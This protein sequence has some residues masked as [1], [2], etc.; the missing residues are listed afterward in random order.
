MIAIGARLDCAFG[1]EC[2]T[3]HRVTSF[4]GGLGIDFFL[5][6]F[7]CA[8]SMPIGFY[9]LREKILSQ[10]LTYFFYGMLALSALI[11]FASAPFVVFYFLG[12]LKIL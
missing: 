8:I 7:T 2:N 6:P 5:S 10:N 9:L 11:I 3:I 1:I 4:D 12:Y